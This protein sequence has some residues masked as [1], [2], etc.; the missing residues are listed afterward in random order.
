MRFQRAVA[1]LISALLVAPA[2][3]QEEVTPRTTP[4]GL[5]TVEVERTQAPRG[6][7]SGGPLSASESCRGPDYGV[8]LDWLFPVTPCDSP[9]EAGLGFVARADGVVVTS[10]DL[11]ANADEISVILQ[12][13]RRIRADLMAV[14]SATR[15]ALLRIDAEDLPTK[16]THTSSALSRGAPVRTWLPGTCGEGGGQHT[17][18]LFT[19]FG[20][21]EREGELFAVFAGRFNSLPGAPLMDGHGRVVGMVASVVTLPMPVG[22]PLH[23]VEAVRVEAIQPL[24]DEVPTRDP[25]T[26]RLSLDGLDWDWGS[27][28]PGDPLW[29][30]MQD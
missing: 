19:G 15:A 5:V 30:P 9:T 24:V 14:D 4:T 21:G 1:H 27:F 25:S 11:V 10:R 23:V 26:P 22:P 28:F 17:T 29:Q 6:C 13:G 2:M 18:G 16:R 3:G 12:E 8:C 7:S 20:Q